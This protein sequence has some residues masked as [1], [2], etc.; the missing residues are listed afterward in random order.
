MIIDLKAH[1]LSTRQRVFH[2]L[3][4][5]C[6]IEEAIRRSEGVLS[7]KGALVVHTGKYTGRSPQDKFIVKDSET[8]KEVWWGPANQ[9]MSPEAADSLY[10]KIVNHLS[11][12]DVFVQDAHVGMS[13]KWQK[14]IRVITENAWH[15]LFARNMFVRLDGPDEGFTPDFTVYH[16]PSFK[17]VPSQD[18]TN[19]EVAV[20]LDFSKKRVLICGTEYAGEV[21]KSIFSVLNF[22]YPASGVLGMHCSASVGQAGDSAIYFGLSGTGKTTLS[23]D[24]SRPLIGDDEH[25]WC[26]EGIFNFEGGCYAKVIRLSEKDEPEIFGM[27]QKFGTILENVVVDPKTRRLDLFDERLTENTRASYELG[28]LGNIEPSGQGAHPK[29]IV[30]LTCDAYGVLPPIARLTKE[31]AMYHFLSGY[32]AK[33]AGTERGVT[34]PTA[35][36]SACFGAPFMPR[37]PG[38][39]AKLLGD[40]MS[41]HQANCWLLNTGWAEGPYGVGKRMKISW[42]RTLLNAALAGELDGA[43][44]RTD[45]RFGFEVPT[46]VPG[47]PDRI[48]NPRGTWPDP[49]EYD[50]KA[51]DLAKRFAENFKKFAA[52]VDEDIIASAPKVLS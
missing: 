17:A 1:G 11:E 37:F 52:S 44:Y 38:D 4:V 16:A 20:V 23:A 13:P 25:G 27:T 33:V 30:M 5:S 14:A 49:I 19:S 9:A 51:D 28:E 24:P 45:E 47:V 6:L 40:K 35:V 48:L 46:A 10:T 22:V 50:R 43:E 39:Y 18:Q 36:F 41:E 7:D 31:Q 26:N 8:E 3:T 29:N 12:R 21:K 42:T 2:N 32:T 34:E 15:A